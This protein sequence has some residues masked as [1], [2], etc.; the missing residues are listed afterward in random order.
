[1]SCF[2]IFNLKRSDT[3]DVHTHLFRERVKC[4]IYLVC[5][6]MMFNIYAKAEI[7]TTILQFLISLNA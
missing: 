4:D 3:T 1:M 2:T 6:R 7:E 5:V